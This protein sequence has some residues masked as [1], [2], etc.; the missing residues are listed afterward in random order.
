MIDHMI[1][2]AE[3]ITAFPHSGRAVPE[4]EHEDVREI[5]ESPYRL[6]YRILP[7]RIDVL[8]VMHC[9]R[10]LREIPGL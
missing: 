5:I 2:R 3:Q 4:Y 8:S 9:A 10:L 6:I 1:R 7:Y